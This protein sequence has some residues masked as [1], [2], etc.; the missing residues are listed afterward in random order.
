[1]KVVGSY[2]DNGY[3][4]LQ[5]LIPP[6][7]AQ[8]FLQGLKQDIGPGAIP[9]SRVESHPNLLRRA[10]FEVY[11][12]HYKPMLYF[13]WGLTPIIRDI[14]G[15]ELLPTYDYFR[16]Y[17]EGDVCRVHSDRQSCEHSLSLTLDYSDGEIWDLQVGKSRHPEPSAKVDED[18]GPEPFASIPMQVGDAVLYQGVNHRHGRVKPNPNGW[19]AHLFLHWVDRDGPYR[20]HAFDGQIS[21]TKVNFSF[22]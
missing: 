12:H 2:H 16:I 15:R 6:E 3:A 10:A 9:L 22:A 7:V 4:H 13:L 14:I 8:A 19:S 20:D 21:P 1:V 11:G 5:E 18:F 17:R